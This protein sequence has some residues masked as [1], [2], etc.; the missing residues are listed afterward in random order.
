MLHRKQ[1]H[2]FSKRLLKMHVLDDVKR[3]H[4]RSVL[5]Q[6]PDF[7]FLTM[8]FQ[9][10]MIIT[11]SPYFCVPFTIFK[12]DSNSLV[13]FVLSEQRQIIQ[14]KA[15]ISRFLIVFGTEMCRSYPGK[16]NTGKQEI[17]FQIVS[18]HQNFVLQP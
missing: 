5:S 8:N 9:S 1:A 2:I 17:A 6:E 14:V 13:F 12:R 16:K 11:S 15:R 7:V 18:R 3:P 4:R 10:P